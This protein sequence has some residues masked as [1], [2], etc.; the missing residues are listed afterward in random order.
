[1]A[2]ISLNLA[3][4]SAQE[5]ILKHPDAWPVMCLPYFFTFG[6]LPFSLKDHFY[7]EVLYKL[8]DIPQTITM[9]TGR[10]VGKSVGIAAGTHELCWTQ[11]YFKSLVFSPLCS[12]V[13]YL[14]D[15]YFAPLIEE[16]PIRDKIVGK[17]NK[18]NS[19]YKEFKNGSA[20]IFT[21]AYDSPDRIR[22]KSVDSV[23]GDEM[24][25]FNYD[26]MGVIE[27][28]MSARKHPGIRKY[29]GTP[30]TLD[31]TLTRLFEEGSQAEWVTKCSHCNK[32]NIPNL[33]NH[34]IKMLGKAGLQ[35]AH[36][37]KPIYPAE[38]GRWVHA[39]PDRRLLHSSY[40]VPQIIC[41]A[42]YAIREKWDRVML[43]FE[44]QP[45]HMFY[46]EV[47]G[48]PCDTGQKLVS[49]SDLKAAGVIDIT[50]DVDDV[51]E[52][53]RGRYIR[54]ALG[55]D[56]SGGGIDY[57]S[58]TGIALV[59]LRGD[60]VVEVPFLKV[61]PYSTDHMA[62]AKL[63]LEY[64]NRLGAH[65]LAHDFSGAG[66][67]R[68]TLLVHSG[69][70]L[71]RIVPITLTR[72]NGSKGIMYYNNPNDTAVRNSWTLDKG[73]SLVLTC[74]LIKSKGL[75]L[76]K[77]EKFKD[78]L[79]HFLA[80]IEHYAESPTSGPSFSVHRAVG[81][82]DDLAHAVNFGTMAVFNIEDAW[83]NISNQFLGN[84][85]L[86]TTEEDL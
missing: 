73:R 17:H 57:Q 37:G 41:P 11:K 32:D 79:E 29:F 68:E 50:D 81:K 60:G 46:N 51:R 31:N 44:R 72:T 65:V 10:Q 40:H 3:Y 84:Y 80:L 61:L 77:Y 67:V 33:D 19:L 52:F 59:G 53:I 36:C 26:F 38:H 43:K 74:T 4:K 34:V 55:V 9:M 39:R 66:N 6:G 18:Q 83:P 86:T 23:T 54:T 64:A 58:F 71:D 48:Q 16:S 14:S 20:E 78:E 42:H 85:K 47:L 27:E 8:I 56:W 13:Q 21:Y 1:M 76:P 75:I 7:T 69:W 28:C 12:Q 22:G 45:K 24:Q 30:K 5:L 49:L 35:C 15:T 25:D 70:P 63:V 82:P 62:E 2:N